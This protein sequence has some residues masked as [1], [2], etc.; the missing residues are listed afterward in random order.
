MIASELLK[1][2]DLNITQARKEI[3]SLLIKQESPIN[4]AKMRKNLPQ[5]NESTFYR[6]LEKMVEAKL[7]KKINLGNDYSHYE[8]NEVQNK[9]EATHHHHHIICTQCKSIECLD[10][11][12]IET[13]L[14]PQI[15]KLGYTNISH[16]LEFFGLCSKCQK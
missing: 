4:V 2:F 6:N 10:I 8:F 5:F 13:F 1:R 16:R 11:C 3:L 12:G 15:K 7:I 9:K 14:H